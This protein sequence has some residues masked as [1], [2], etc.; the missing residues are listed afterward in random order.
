[1]STFDSSSFDT[2]SFSSSSF[3]LEEEE[4][5]IDPGGM[6]ISSTDLLDKHWKEQRINDDELL[7][8]V[9]KMVGMG[10]L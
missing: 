9:A 7:V 8:I 5:V 6:L 2:S 3:D 10:L 1:M 4:V